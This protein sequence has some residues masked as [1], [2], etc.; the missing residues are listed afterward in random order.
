MTDDFYVRYAE[1]L[2]TYLRD[3]DEAALAVGHDLGRQALQGRMSVLDI[4][5]NHTKLV[6]VFEILDARPLLLVTLRALEESARGDIQRGQRLQE[7]LKC[8]TGVGR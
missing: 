5:E 3:R 4:I 1:A 8:G 2:N 7:E 6:A